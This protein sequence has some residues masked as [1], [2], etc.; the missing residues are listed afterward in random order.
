MAV[1]VALG[2]LAF[3]RLRRP[4]LTW[5]ASDAEASARLPGDELLEEAN[6]VATRAI[7]I[8]AP[9]G[10]VWP[11]L[12]QMGPSPR[13]GV[14]TYDWIENLLGL[15]IHSVDRV[16]P[17]FQS[18]QA[19]ETIEFGANTM[20]LERV[21]SE[22]VL[23]WRSLDGNWVWSFVLEERDGRTRLISRNRYRLPTLALRIAMLPMEPGSL[24]MERKMLHGI[25]ARAEALA[26]SD[27]PVG[28][29]RHWRDLSSRQRCGIL[30][31][32]TAQLTLLLA[33]LRDLHRRP[34]DQINGSRG[35]WVAV[36]F[37]NFVGPLS[38]FLFGRRRRA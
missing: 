11:W 2:S 19:G 3:A 23:A 38:Y 24:V 12:A 16:L 10:A 26:M 25:R 5:G 7:W 18:P 21:E 13:G 32:S 27:C 8:D 15:N 22:R 35:V 4:I 17:E 31:A 6:G 37:V 33:A 36:S 20:R 14:Y 9:A 28:H 1:G 30:V 29:K 34:A